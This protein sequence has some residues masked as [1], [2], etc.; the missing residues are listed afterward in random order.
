ML[1]AVQLLWV[2][3]IMDT[4]A[5]LA[6]ATDP[7][8][9]DSLKRKPDK[10]MAPLIS[11]DMWKMIIG[12]SIFQLIAAFTLH[13][14]GPAIFGTHGGTALEELNKERRLDTL[15]FNQFVWCQIFNLLNARVL[16]RSYN[17]FSGFWRN[18]YFM[19]ILGIMVGG[20]ILIVFVGGAAF[21]VTPINGIYWAISIIIGSLALPVGV[22]V[23]TIPTAPVERMMIK[24]RLYPDPSALP[25]VA[26][27]SEDAQWNEGITK[28]IDNLKVLSTVRGGR[29]RSSSIVYKSRSA[30]LEKA[31]VHPSS[32]LAMVPS[33]VF[34]SVGAGWKPENGEATLSDPAAADPSRSSVALWRGLVQL[35][36]ETRKQS[37]R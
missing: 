15:I 5:A 26:P 31:G 11:P 21:Q 24:M 34:A 14:A 33:L 27:E 3:L 9:P 17:V 19:V 35:H 13:F 6:L 30:Q 1:T 23:R 8:T 10:K 36:P 18:Y 37:V 7:A 29:T 28:V 2:N 25:E 20:Q 4:F 12:Q 22:I 16:D 32:L